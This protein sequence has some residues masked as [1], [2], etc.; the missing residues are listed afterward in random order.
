[1]TIL[2]TPIDIPDV[3]IDQVKLL[4]W[5]H[6]NKIYD[7]E[8]WVF[9]DGR[10][11]WALAAASQT[12]E[13]WKR[14]K[15][16][17]DWLEQDHKPSEGAKLQ[18]APQFEETFPDLARAI[19]AMPFKEIGAVGL[20]KQLKYIEP[21]RDTKDPNNPQEPRRYMIYLTDPNENTFF[22]TDRYDEEHVYDLKINPDYPVFAF[23]NTD[24]KHGAQP[25]KGDKILIS[26][27]GIIDEE[28]HEELIRRSVAKFEDWVVRLDDE[29]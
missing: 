29:H 21:H 23:N 20:L 24:V 16:Y 12:P 25:P 9:K 26:V 17:E 15:P 2:Y 19:R 3:K 18:F 5:F 11:E 8:F 27:V 4:E 7:P 14:I 1:M 28:R 10:H 13:N 22:M 6:E